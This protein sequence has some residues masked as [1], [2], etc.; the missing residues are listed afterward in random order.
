M[1]KVSVRDVVLAYLFVQRAVYHLLMMM[2]DLLIP[3]RIPDALI[4]ESVMMSVQYWII[5][6]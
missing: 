6:G 5:V 1:R 2:K 3:R 4:A